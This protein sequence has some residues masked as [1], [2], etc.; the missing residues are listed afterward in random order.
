[1]SVS[2]AKAAE[3]LDAAA[4][5]LDALAQE[6]NSSARAARHAHIDELANKYAEATGEEMPDSIRRKLAESDK[7]VVALVESMATRQASAI[8]SLGGPST[9]NDDAEPKTT[10]EAAAKADDRFLTWVMS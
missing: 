7:D 2:L 1:M 6:K 10:K 4:D 5:H 3:V 8:E 9:L